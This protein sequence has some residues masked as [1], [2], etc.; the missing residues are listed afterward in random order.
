VIR[1]LTDEHIPRA[2][3]DALLDR[4]V[5]VIRV[6]DFGL[7]STPD[8]DILEWAA[9]QSRVFVTFDRGTVPGF[10]YDR[11]RAGLP[12]PG[13]VVVDDTLSIGSM[14]DELHVLAACGTLDDFRDQV[15]YIPL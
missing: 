1:L 6:Q 14:T 2:L 8:P 9:A 13:V 15:V 12:M 4:G 7:D 3:I 10:A 5:D 11:I